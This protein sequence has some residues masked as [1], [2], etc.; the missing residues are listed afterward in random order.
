MAPGRSEYFWAYLA[1]A[2]A[3]DAV[4]E[5]GT[6]DNDMTLVSNQKSTLAISW[7]FSGFLSAEVF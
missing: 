5:T 2:T 1:Q 6:G 7:F 4:S 3:R